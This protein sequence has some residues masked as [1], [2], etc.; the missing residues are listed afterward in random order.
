MPAF[1]RF[2]LPALS[3][4]T[5][6][7]V[8]ASVGAAAPS[9]ADPTSAAQPPAAT[10]E[11]APGTGSVQHPRH[12]SDGVAGP[13]A[14]ELPAGRVRTQILNETT[15]DMAPGINFRRWDQI[16]PRGPI[17][18]Q[19]LTIDINNPANEF[20]IVSPAKVPVRKP[21]SELTAKSGAVAA[22]NGDFFDIG[23]TGAPLGV[24]K[25]REKGMRNAPK[26]GWNSSFWVDSVGHPYV[27]ELP[28][29]GKLK[30]H[31]KLKFNN[32]NSP[33][34]QANGIGVFDKT[35]GPTQGSSVTAGQKRVREVIVQGR[36]RAVQQDEGLRGLQ[37]QGQGARVRGPRPGHE[38][39]QEGQ[40]GREGH[41]RR[42]DRRLADHGHQR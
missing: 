19:L 27:G 21:V 7:C 14:P 39:A 15:W 30:Q 24:G 28:Y 1:T 26:E 31:P 32:H 9:S 33:S 2:A 12:S 34:I 40:G 20:D 37:D 17:R 25:D 42:V 36:R 22:V 13:I 10:G 18:A 4:A 35:W 41:R 5:T 16:D 38:D 6:A 23:D 3:L 29:K 11:R 8:V